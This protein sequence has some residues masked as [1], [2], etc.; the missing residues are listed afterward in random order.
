M[1]VGI[2]GYAGV[3]KTSVFSLLTGQ[4]I[5]SHV[6]GERHLASVEVKDP[7]LAALRDLWQPRKY[8]PARFEVVDFPALPRGSEKGAG[9]R[10]AMLREM[11]ALIVVIGAFEQARL[12]L[13]ADLA[14]PELQWKAFQE[15][16]LL[17]DMDVLERRIARASERLQKG[18]GDR[19]ALQREIDLLRTFLDPLEN[20]APLPPASEDKAVQMMR[21]ELGLFLDKPLIAVFNA[22]EGVRPGDPEAAKLASLA[23]RSAV[24]SAPVEQEIAQIDA[25]ER[26]EFL[27]EYGLEEA[28]VDRLTRLA[29]EATRLISF[30]TVGPDEVRAWPIAAGSDAVT[31]AGKIHSDLARGFIRAEVLTYDQV[32][33]VRDVK[34]WKAIKAELKGKD[35]VVGDG[36]I[37]N[38][39]FSV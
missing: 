14:T 15:D 24:L 25:A 34:D 27:A 33:E 35:H 26:G 17:L 23:D 39:R 36:D 31:A 4:E 16:I 5:T 28:A 21:D 19:P 9:E 2:T 38:I 20:G 37:L 1:K 29:F 8:T 12:S 7:R 30:F 3:G 6:P 18:A 11:E 22:E 13:P 32:K 10:I